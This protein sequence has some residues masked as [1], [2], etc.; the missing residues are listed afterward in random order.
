MIR[1]YVFGTCGLAALLAVSQDWA[2][3]AQTVQGNY[4]GLIALA[5]LALFTEHQALVIGRGKASGGTSIGFLP[6]FTVLVL[7]GPAA[8]VAV[9]MVNGPI[10]EYLI[11]QKEPLRAN[12]NIAQYVAA[13]GLG[14]LAFT[15]VGGTPLMALPDI[16]RAAGIMEQVGPFIVF[17]V[18]VLLFNNTAVAL[19]I[20][21]SEGLAFREVWDAVVTQTG[22]NI[23]TDLLVAPVAIA[24]AALYVQ[25]GTLG[26]VLAI[27]PLLFIR[28][29][30]LTTFRLQQA[31]RDLLKALVKAIET[32]DPYT[33]GHSVRVARL[34]TAIAED[35][36]FPSKRVDELETAALLHD[37]GKID[38]V[39]S[40][41]L[42]K[43]SALS[44]EERAI[45]ESHV[46]KGAEFIRSLTSFGDEVVL[47]VLH[48]H[49]HVDGSGYPDGLKAEEIPMGARIIKVCDAIDAMLSDRPYRKALPVPEVLNQLR[50][51]AGRQF[52]PDIVATVLKGGVIPAHVETLGSAHPAAFWASSQ[53]STRSAKRMGP[54]SAPP[55]DDGAQVGV[56]ALG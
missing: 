19:A 29:A 51:Y 53:L 13:A 46:T 17:G 44:D 38:G 32:R 7:F 41:I 26:L 14:G 54:E 11:R 10:V 22:V 34:A 3:F 15:L 9:M 39:Y 4:W 30:Y 45:I 56:E 1:L 48:H 36:G 40:E 27:L 43:P 24:V 5:L 12:F 20:A 8:T 42:K 55:R 28:H 25:I 16:A 23:V 21:L 6:L 47:P 2:A 52:D 37:I 31:N 35:M 49:E 50:L 33:S 18:V